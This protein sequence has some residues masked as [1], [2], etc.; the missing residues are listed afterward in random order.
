MTLYDPFQMPDSRTG[1]VRILPSTT[2]VMFPCALVPLQLHGPAERQMLQDAV[3]SDLLI[4]SALLEPG[5]ERYDL[6]VA[7]L[8]S[9]TCVCR[10]MSHT[11]V[12]TD[13]WNVLLAGIGRASIR[14]E[15][16]TEQPYRQAE[17]NYLEDY[18]ADETVDARRE[19]KHHL[20]DSFRRQLPCSATVQQQL[21][22]LWTAPIA[23]GYLTDVIAFSLGLP[24]RIKQCLLAELDVNRRA[25]MLLEQLARIERGQYAAPAIFPP[26]FS[27]N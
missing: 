7:P 18:Y 26:E 14:H 13:R 25:E 10:I 27:L 6:N 8:A 19:L 22:L 12:E 11:Q 4:A 17:V 5:W 24:P 2:L 9:M 23:L 20:L 21:D 15:L 3:A 1:D 16:H